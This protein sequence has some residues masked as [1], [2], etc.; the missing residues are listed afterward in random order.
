MAPTIGVFVCDCKGQ[1]SD[2]LDTERVAQVAESLESVAFVDRVDVLCSKSDLGAAI[3]KVKDSGCDRLLF[4]GCSPRSSLSF[5]EERIATVML[6]VGLSPD[7]FEVANIRE[8]CAWQHPDRDAATGKAVDLIRMAHARLVHDQPTDRTVPIAQNALIIG[9]GAAGLQA[10]KDL[11]SAGIDV[12]IAERNPWLGG[13]VCQVHRL[14]QSEA[15]PSVCDAS[16]VGPVQAKG[17]VLSERIDT[18]IQT[19][20]V[21]VSKSNG[22]FNVS[23]QS[24]PL[25][26]DPELCISC[27]ECAQVC[28]EETDRRYDHGATKRKAIDK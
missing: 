18:R 22:S 26:V 6:S 23:L 24:D 28:P 9:G 17:A 7:L 12:T 5:P 3:R 21:G 15:W 2:H 8:Q 25:F 11:A 20:V 14:F 19:R 27:G 4:A 1:V 10:A 13:H 16:C